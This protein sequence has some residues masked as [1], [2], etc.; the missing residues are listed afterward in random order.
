MQEPKRAASECAGVLSND[1]VVADQ[2]VADPNC[3]RRYT[4]V[5]AA[6]LSLQGSYRAL[7]ALQYLVFSVCSMF[8]SQTLP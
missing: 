6:S 8:S 1:D 7:L 2:C 5:A 4:T 3:N